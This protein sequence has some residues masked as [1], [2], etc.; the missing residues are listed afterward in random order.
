MAAPRC[1]GLQA[2]QSTNEFHGD[3]AP[4]T[5]RMWRKRMPAQEQRGEI[6]AAA[7]DDAHRQARRR[8]R[9]GEASSQSARSPPI[10]ISSA[11]MTAL[12][13]RTRASSAPQPGRG[14]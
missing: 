10:Q 2:L 1:L 6:G 13:N 11:A 3:Y 4:A 7:A 14:L 8:A 5:L 9:S 12:A